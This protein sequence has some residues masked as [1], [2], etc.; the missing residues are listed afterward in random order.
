[1]I[2]LPKGANEVTSEFSD[3]LTG[4]K[5]ILKDIWEHKDPWIAKVILIKKSN[6]GKIT[7]HQLQILL[8][9]HGQ[10][11]SSTRRTHA[12]KRGPRNKTTHL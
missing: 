7:E 8:K 4:R 1:M 9:I 3:I 11:G 2:I 6:T 5:K 10:Y 12:L